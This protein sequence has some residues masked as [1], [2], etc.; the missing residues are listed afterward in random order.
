MYA[1]RLLFALTAVASSAG[2]LAAERGATQIFE[3][4]ASGAASWRIDGLTNP[5]L[6]LQ[7][8]GTYI[9][10][11]NNVGPTH[12][13]NINTINAPGPNFLYNDG[14]TN[15]GAVGSVDITFVVPANAPATLHYNC[16]NHVTMNGPITITAADAI[17]ADDFEGP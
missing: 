10:R 14:V 9:F 13:F 7:R 5:P 1:L 2:S 4:S 3:V 17:F 12:P 11:L 16:E 6:T 15:N 8:G